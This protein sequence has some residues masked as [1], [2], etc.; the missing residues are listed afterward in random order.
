MLKELFLCRC[1]DRSDANQFLVHELLDS[2]AGELAPVARV[3]NAADRQ[4]RR[5][6]SRVVDEYH[7]RVDA[8]RPHATARYQIAGPSHLPANFFAIW[9]TWRPWNRAIANSF[10]LGTRFP[11]PPASVP[12]PYGEPPVISAI[13]SRRVSLYGTPTITMP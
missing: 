3:F 2:H 12:A 11:S 10:S 5:R 7:A 6:P 1:V 8:A 4:I 13:F 9:V